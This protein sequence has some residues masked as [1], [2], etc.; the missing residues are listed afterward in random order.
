MSVGLIAK[1]SPVIEVVTIDTQ[2]LGDR[3]Y[4]VTDGGSAFVIDPQRDVDRVFAAAAARGVAVTDVFETHI[5]NDYVSGGLAVARR[6]GA[7]YYV[8]AADP[9]AFGRVGITDGDIIT[10]GP[11][12]RVRVIATPGHTFTHLA[13]ALQDAVTGEWVAVF[14]G[15]SLL[16]GSTGRP[17]LLGSQ[18][19]RTL[20]A[21]QHASAQ[22]LAQVLPD[23]SAVYPT[24][25]FGSFCAATATAGR[26]VSTIGAEKESNPALTLPADSYVAALVATLDDYP[27][28]YAHMAAVN[29]A[30]PDATDPAP[31]APV[32]ADELDRRIAAGEW[33]VDLRHRRAFAAGHVAGSFSFEFGDSFA[34]YLGWLIPWGAPLTLIGETDGQIAAAQRELSRIGVDRLA[35]AVLTLSPDWPASGTLATYSISDF[36]GLAAER[37]RQDIVI[38]DVRRATERA[39]GYL[40]GSL[41]VPLHELPSRLGALPRRPVW[42]HCQGGYR[43]SIAASLLHA[44]GREVT[45]V[46]GDFGTAAGAGLALSR[47]RQKRAA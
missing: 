20:A 44:A 19:T 37:D 1:E 25:G 14:T 34:T 33:V 47:P 30:G 6:S 31:P 15:G 18:H 35:G 45:A 46:D 26:S 38:L 21:A 9:V 13:Y 36:A 41:H 39:G 27:A 7:S 3:T 43:A 22:R 2:S 29:R 11:S 42:V 28:Y 32:R 17:D 23:Q 8:N 10:V 4:L 24:H 5:H 16:Y 40:E 12:M